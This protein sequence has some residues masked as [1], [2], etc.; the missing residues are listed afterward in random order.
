MRVVVWSF[1]FFIDFDFTYFFFTMQYKGG[2]FK[3]ITVIVYCWLI[4]ASYSHPPFVSTAHPCLVY[5]FMQFHLIYLL[6][7][8]CTVCILFLMCILLL[9]LFNS[10]L[11]LCYLATIEWAGGSVRYAKSKVSIT[12]VARSS[13]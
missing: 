10:F 6:Y 3:L 9:A 13:R 8:I 11:L 1:F 2:L 7:I 12:K 4:N 5:S